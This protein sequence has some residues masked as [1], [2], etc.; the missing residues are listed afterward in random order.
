MGWGIKM[1]YEEKISELE[2]KVKTLETIIS[3][4]TLTNDI[5]I[6]LS[7]YIESNEELYDKINKINANI[8]NNVNNDRWWKC[9]KCPTTVIMY[10][11][12]V[13][14]IGD[15]FANKYVLSSNTSIMS[16]KI[17]DHNKTK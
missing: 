7:K 4:Y 8:T 14:F 2:K 3:K 6:S 9:H 10:I 11:L 17:Q 12:I 15:H 1:N 5:K 13:A 16:E